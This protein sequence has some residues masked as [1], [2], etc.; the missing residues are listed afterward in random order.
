ME[1]KRKDRKHDFLE[2]GKETRSSPGSGHNEFLI[3]LFEWDSCLFQEKKKKIIILD[4]V[5]I[6]KFNNTVW[7]R[8]KV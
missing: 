6:N 1:V 2:S 7:V 8:I 3:T 5:V 4:K